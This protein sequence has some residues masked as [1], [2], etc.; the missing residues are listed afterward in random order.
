MKHLNRNELDKPC[1]THDVV[2]SDSKAM[3]KR[4][5]SDKILKDRVYEIARNRIYHGY[6]DNH[7]YG[8]VFDKKEDRK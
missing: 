3:A 8:K 5:I 1:F 6:L 4:T 7:N 2:D